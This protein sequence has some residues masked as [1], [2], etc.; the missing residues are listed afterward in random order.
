VTGAGS[1]DS[2]SGGLPDWVEPQLATLTE[3]RFSDPGWIYERKLDGERCLAFVQDG[4]VRLLTRNRKSANGSYPELVQALAAQGAGAFIVDGEV[5]AFDGDN[6]SF[7]L[8]QQRIH[9]SR[10][11]LDLRARIPVYFYLF[12]ILYSG[13]TDVRPQPLR[14]RKDLLRGQLA[15]RDPL[16]YTEYRTGDG[17]AY[18]K[19][20]CQDGWEGII[21]K[22]AD[23]PYRAG[24]SKDWLKFKCVTGQEFVIGGYTDPRGARSGFGALLLGYYDSDG[25]LVYAGKVGTGFDE[26]TLRALHDELASL[27]RKDPPFQRGK[28]PK[29]GVHW[30]RPRLVAQ[31]AFSEWTSDGMLRHPRFQGLR[32]DKKPAEVV[33]ETA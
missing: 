4:E 23:A 5:V 33:R 16:R 9:V 27:E 11:S 20:A 8:L 31:I 15:F 6:T 7:A 17:V 12:D 2:Q 32:R 24:R 30:V 10:P 21:A 14:E 29:S 13:G 1:A 18:W 26:R 22:R 28:L 19:Q 3:D 25:R